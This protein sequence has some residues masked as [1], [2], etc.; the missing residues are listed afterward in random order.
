MLGSNQKAKIDFLWSEG[1]M[2]LCLP[3]G[4]AS[5]MLPTVELRLSAA[6]AH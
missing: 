2:R 3:G 4:Y 1:A 6:N 5:M